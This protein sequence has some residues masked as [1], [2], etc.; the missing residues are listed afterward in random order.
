MQF[1]C[2]GRPKPK[3]SI[4]DSALLCSSGWLA[5]AFVAQVI[6]SSP[7]YPQT[8][9]LS[10]PTKCWDVGWAALCLADIGMFLDS[11]V[12]GSGN[13]ATQMGLGGNRIIICGKYKSK[14]WVYSLF[15]AS[16]R[17][18]GFSSLIL[19]RQMRRLDCLIA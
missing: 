5:A 10:Q 17:Q 6:H 19:T 9:I 18:E 1:R 3:C 7:G 4:R 13:Y 11:D 16:L 15:K 8:H 12:S 14:H 2:F